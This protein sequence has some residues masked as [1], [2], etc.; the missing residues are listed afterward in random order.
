MCFLTI[1]SST[2][3]AWR[4]VRCPAALALANLVRIGLGSCWHE[5]RS[6]L[7]ARLPCLLSR[8]RRFTTG[9]F[10]KRIE[11]DRLPG[12][13][14][15]PSCCLCLATST[16]LSRLSVRS[17]GTPSGLVSQRSSRA[18]RQTSQCSWRADDWLVWSRPRSWVSRRS[19]A[20]LADNL[21]KLRPTRRGV[22]IPGY[23]ARVSPAPELFPNWEEQ[24]GN[25]SYSSCSATLEGSGPTRPSRNCFVDSRGSSVAWDRSLPGPVNSATEL[26]HSEV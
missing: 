11:L 13:L 4:L 24:L 26:L 1:A 10:R 9:A 25:E 6:P 17:S 16:P 20:V 21:R 5:A 3:G 22:R 12:Y 18:R 7:R 14:R 23:C 15:R 2:S 19:G 8:K